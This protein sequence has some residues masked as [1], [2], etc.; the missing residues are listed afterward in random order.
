M[1]RLT[2]TILTAAVITAQH[3][4]LPELSSEMLI[5]RGAKQV[6]AQPQVLELWWWVRAQILQS[7]YLVAA[8]L[9]DLPGKEGGSAGGLGASTPLVFGALFPPL[10]SA[11]PVTAMC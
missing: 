7:H 11:Q 4:E 10:L 5:L 9:Q 2:P 1:H 3:V 8:E 6:V